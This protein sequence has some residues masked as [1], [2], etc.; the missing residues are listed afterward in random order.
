MPAPFPLSLSPAPRPGMS[1]PGLCALLRGTP[2]S[3]ER[4]G[5]SVV[6][7]TIN[8][9]GFSIHPPSNY[10]LTRGLGVGG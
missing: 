5:L 2:T 10:N 1:F 3:S 6:H 7:V 8:L 4:S 9:D